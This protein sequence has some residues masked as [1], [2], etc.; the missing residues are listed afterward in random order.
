MIGTLRRGTN[1]LVA[2]ALVAGLLA[3]AATAY[4]TAAYHWASLIVVVAV[5]S[6]V[7]ALV[8]RSLARVP[9]WP[10]LV[11]ASVPLTVRTLGAATVGG[12]ADDASGRA[13]D[14][15]ADAGLELSW[16]VTPQFVGDSVELVVTFADAAAL[17]AIALLVVAQVQTFTRLRMT[18]GFGMLFVVVT[19]MGLAGFWA[20]VRWATAD[21]FG[22]TF[23]A[24]NE[25]LM[26]EFAT[27]AL[28]GFLVAV[29]FG[30]YFCRARPAPRRQPVGQRGV[31]R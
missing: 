26:H 17:A 16:L 15:A 31:R 2:W 3:L 7:P 24:T 25:A 19:T 5:L 30:P 14:Y 28:A 13:F 18:T 9:P 23:V 10:L 4:A 20:I 27:T 29:V 21:V 1:A 8:A 11:V 22:L 12:T 6:V